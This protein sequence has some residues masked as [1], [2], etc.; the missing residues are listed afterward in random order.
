VSLAKTTVQPGD[1]PERRSI[2]ASKCDL[3]SDEMVGE[4]RAFEVQ[5]CAAQMTGFA[6]LLWDP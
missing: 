5:C 1:M 6:P 4:A 3:C 2:V